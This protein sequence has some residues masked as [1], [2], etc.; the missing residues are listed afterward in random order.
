MNELKPC[1]FCGKQMEV[2]NEVH[3]YYVSYNCQR[4]CLG[5]DIVCMNRDKNISDIWNTR[6]ID[7]RLVEA[8][9]KIDFEISDDVPLPKDIEL[10][11][12]RAR[13]IL[14]HHIPELKEAE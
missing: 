9:E 11:L 1:P 10:G 4:G 6:A 8:V 3:G 5:D 13:R 2:V 12:T 7:K 14:G